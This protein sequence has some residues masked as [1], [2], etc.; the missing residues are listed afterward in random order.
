MSVVT[1]P[2]EIHPNSKIHKNNF[3]NARTHKNTYT[4]T[5]SL[6]HTNLH[7]HKKHTQTWKH[8]TKTFE[9]NKHL[10]H[11]K[12]LKKKPSIASISQNII[13]FLA[14]LIGGGVIKD[15]VK[16]TTTPLANKIPTSGLQN[17]WVSTSWW[18]FLTTS[19]SDG[20][21]HYR[22]FCPFVLTCKWKSINK[23]FKHFW[24]T[25]HFSTIKVALSKFCCHDASHEK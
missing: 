17:F 5:L 19:V 7:T 23:H 18:R 1:W 21:K 16:K 12:K 4:Q 15:V 6:T 14:L 2:E 3:K 13:V 8:Q 11:D 24:N 10:L 25:Q 22:C 9:N 20:V